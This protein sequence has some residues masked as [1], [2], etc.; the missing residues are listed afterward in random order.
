ME[1][2]DFGT[3]A[4]SNLS[5]GLNRFIEEAG[6]DQCA[7]A[8]NVLNDRGYVRRRDAF[9]SVATGPIHRLPA[10][11]LAV[12]TA[13]YNDTTD[14]STQTLTR[15][16]DRAGSL[17]NVGYIYLGLDMEDLGTLLGSDSNGMFYA[18]FDG[19]DWGYVSNTAVPG[20]M[21]DLE[22]SY[23]DGNDWIAITG[24][25]DETSTFLDNGSNTYRSTLCRSG[26]IS[27]H[28]DTFAALHVDS[29]VSG[30]TSRWFRF[31]ILSTA[32]QTISRISAASAP[33]VA[34][35]GLRAFI[36]PP[37]NG[38]FP[39]RINQRGTVVI[40][41]DRLRRQSDP[42]SH[43]DQYR[44]GSSTY[45]TEWATV[46]G[47]QFEQ[48]AQ[49]GERA[50]EMGPTVELVLAEDEGPALYGQPTWPQPTRNGVLVGAAG[51]AYGVASRLR[52]TITSFY[53]AVL[54]TSRPYTWTTDQWRGG[55]V[56]P[57]FAVASTTTPTSGDFAIHT[58]AASPTSFPTASM[59]LSHGRMRC[60]VRAGAGPAVGEEREII[61]HAYDSATGAHTLFVYPNWT[62]TPDGNNQFIILT[63]HSSLL[64][65]FESRVFEV[66]N[67][68][69]SGIATADQPHVLE[70]TDGASHGYAPPVSALPSIIGRFRVGKELRWVMPAGER[71]SAVNDTVTGWMV[72]ANGGTLLEYDGR[73]LRR[74]R[75]D[76]ESDVAMAIAGDLP[77]EVKRGYTGP[78][79]I[80]LSTLRHVPPTGKYLAVHHQRLFVAG[81]PGEPFAVKWSHPGGANNV[82]PNLFENIV[83]DEEQDPIVGMRVLGD[84][85]IVFTPSALHEAQGPLDSPA[86]GFYEFVSI[87]KGIGF[88]GH[89]AVCTVVTKDGQEQIVGVSASGIYA[90]SQGEPRMVLDAWRRMLPDGVNQEALSG[91][92]A[93]SA[94]QRAWALF[95]I[96][97]KGSSINDRIL[98]WDHFR[99]AWWLWSAPFGISSMAV[100]VDESGREQILFGTVDGF[101]MT[102]SGANT[103]DGQTI[104]SYAMSPFVDL[105][106]GRL[107]T[108]RA[109][110][111]ALQT[112]GD[113]QVELDLF[114]DDNGVQQAMDGVVTS[115]DGYTHWNAGTWNTSP[116]RYQAH[117]F[118]RVTV[119]FPSGTR[120]HR[121]AYRVGMNDPD[122][123]PWALKAADLQVLKRARRGRNY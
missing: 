100:D 38:L 19:I 101:V 20:G 42:T 6:K 25:L 21:L 67:N 112:A 22:V 16:T 76:F 115:D 74:L 9:T 96:P 53:D 73:D 31:R 70:M 58:T 59:Q 36:R 85:L 10:G 14:V 77:D 64:V 116:L 23:W 35:P 63:P 113:R 15:W 69:G 90:Y 12:F 95:A 27:W 26:R 82:W 108:P 87:A 54:K 34:A 13:A 110:I 72:L 97:S 62:A 4:L 75:A 49:L 2:S 30:V 89:D 17:N 117:S 51:S 99:N 78:K 18:D 5:G 44:I 37:I 1:R 43:H 88:A 103:D 91:A 28:T 47:S 71:W 109:V 106:E 93:C 119:N 40:G 11:L 107:L 61:G 3:L 7:D 105:G 111:L 120:P 114:T 68:P 50:E 123:V 86:P 121:I 83:R 56:V 55:Q 66:R 52:K 80:A 65:D 32:T 118:K 98:I 122:G 81:C 45:S 46:L 102:L 104:N 57:A 33:T 39:S 92:L 24:V 79:N 41:A 84:R 94:P 48:G 29:T 60:T 8:L